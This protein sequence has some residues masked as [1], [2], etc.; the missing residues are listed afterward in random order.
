MFIL[1]PRKLMVLMLKPS[2]GDIVL[3]SS[4]FTRFT[5]VVFPALSRPTINTRTS[6]SFALTFLMM[7]NSPIAETGGAALVRPRSPARERAQIWQSGRSKKKF[8]FFRLPRFGF[9]F[10]E[11]DENTRF[12]RGTS[13][14]TRPRLVRCRAP[15]GV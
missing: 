15:S 13:P 9:F 4:P 3:M 7:V 14:R 12:A 5:M 10:R 1:Y 6:F 8:D 2:V 11:G